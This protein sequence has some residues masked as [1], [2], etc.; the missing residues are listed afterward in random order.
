MLIN[1]S[2]LF[3][4]GWLQPELFLRIYCTSMY[5]ILSYYVQYKESML[6]YMDVKDIIDTWCQR[7]IKREDC[8]VR[9]HSIKFTGF[10]SN[11]CSSSRLVE[12]LKR[13]AGIYW[14]SSRVCSISSLTVVPIYFLLS[15]DS[16]ILTTEM[17][18]WWWS[19]GQW[20][21]VVRHAHGSRN[22][23]SSGH[24][25]STVCVLSCH[26]CYYCPCSLYS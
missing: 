8:L 26:C 20:N 18:I 17:F 16:H 15:C 21:A 22:Q 9:N 19:R 1:F 24:Y 7:S 4:F 5:L 12:L 2:E 23:T 25:Y 13:R 10:G 14:T 3:Y 11:R 6:R